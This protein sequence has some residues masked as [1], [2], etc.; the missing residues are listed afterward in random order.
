MPAAF[1]VV[2][3]LPI[4]DIYAQNFLFGYDIDTNK[5]EELIMRHVYIRGIFALI[6]LAAALVTGISGNLAMAALYILI[7]ALFLYS[8]Y[9][10]WKKEKKNR[11]EK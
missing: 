5:K 4:M 7:G 1:L 10:M 6:W 8:T 9:S 3:N 11:G 2:K